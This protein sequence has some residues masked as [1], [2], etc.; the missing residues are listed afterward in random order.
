MDAPTAT[1]EELFV[2]WQALPPV[3][4]QQVLDFIDF[5]LGKY[6]QQ[7]SE[8]TPQKQLRPYGLCLGQFKVPDDFDAPLPDE[9]L[10]G[11][12]N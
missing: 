2:K 11:F 8:T 10:D 1:R 4:Q 9:I 3:F 12:E 5:L 6:G 7:Q